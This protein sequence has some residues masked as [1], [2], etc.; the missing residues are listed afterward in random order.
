MIQKLS[1]PIKILS[2]MLI[3][4]AIALD[5]WYLSLLIRGYTLPD[6]LDKFL[7]I[8]SFA[9]V[10]HVIEGAIAASRAKTHNKNPLN[11]G[12]YTFFVGFVGLWELQKIESQP[13]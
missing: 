8:G 12:I 7:W 3:T 5:I 11:Y 4:G 9:L 1:Y 10:A 6:G 2:T 13:E